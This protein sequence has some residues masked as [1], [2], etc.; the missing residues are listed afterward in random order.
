MTDWG[1]AKVVKRAEAVHGVNTPAG[2]GS[3]IALPVKWRLPAL[4]AH[5]GPPFGKPE[6]GAVIAILFDKAKVFGA[7]N[8]AACELVGGYIDGMTWRLIIKGED[9]DCLS[10]I[11]GINC[12]ADLREARSEGHPV[13]RRGYGLVLGL[14]RFDIGGM[15]RVGKESVF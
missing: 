1:L 5:R 4:G 11:S 9:I 8:K 3:V 14:R 6:F 2:V 15:E 7:S 13:Y 10:G 12:H